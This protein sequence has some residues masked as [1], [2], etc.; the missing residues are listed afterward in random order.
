MRR[1]IFV[2]RRMPV[3]T[4]WVWSAVAA[5][6]TACSIFAATE[7]HGGNAATIGGIAVFTALGA[8]RELAYEVTGQRLP[9]PPPPHSNVTDLRPGP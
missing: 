6:S 8:F 9:L 3:S 7:G 2:G 4:F 5:V 1:A